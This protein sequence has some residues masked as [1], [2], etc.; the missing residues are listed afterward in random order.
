MGLKSDAE[1]A[2]AE[3]RIGKT[4]ALELYDSGRLASLE[5]GTFAALS[6]IHH[7]LFDEIYVSAGKIRT[8]NSAKGNFRFAAALYLDQALA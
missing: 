1:L 4:K 8:V 5:A 2:R 6:F 3:K 7:F